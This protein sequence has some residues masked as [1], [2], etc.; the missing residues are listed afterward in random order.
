MP[1][2]FLVCFTPE[3]ARGPASVSEEGHKVSGVGGVG[4]TPHMTGQDL[5]TATGGAL[6]WALMGLGGP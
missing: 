5:A 6:H 3:K 1:L 2:A 4:L